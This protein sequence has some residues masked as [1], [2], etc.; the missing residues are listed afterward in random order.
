MNETSRVSKEEKEGLK[1]DHTLLEEERDRLL[2]QIK[3]YQ[4][5]MHHLNA[6]FTS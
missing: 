2:K 1:Y 4:V 5:I 6:H 3:E